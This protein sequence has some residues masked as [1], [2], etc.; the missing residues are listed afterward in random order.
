MAPWTDC[1]EARASDVVSGSLGFLF[2]SS[3]KEVRSYAQGL[4]TQRKHQARGAPPPPLAPHRRWRLTLYNSSVRARSGAEMATNTATPVHAGRAHTRGWRAHGRDARCTMFS[5]RESDGQDVP[6]E[7]RRDKER[8]GEAYER[9]RGQGGGRLRERYGTYD[10]GGGGAVRAGNTGE[11]ESGFVVPIRRLPP[12]SHRRK[13]SC[14]E[15]GE[16]FR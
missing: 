9:P 7:T 3:G 1:T 14:C 13:R 11:A 15:G 2:Q 12:P 4:C 8:P 5:V 10:N 16:E 6:G